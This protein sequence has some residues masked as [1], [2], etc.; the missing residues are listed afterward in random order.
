MP[1]EID[2]TKLGNLVITM[3]STFPGRIAIWNFENFKTADPPVSFI[4]N[5]SNDYITDAVSFTVISSNML[6]Y[7][8][9]NPNRLIICEFTLSNTDKTICTQTNDKPIFHTNGNHKSASSIVLDAT[10][11]IYHD[12]YVCWISNGLGNPFTIC[13][14][15]AASISSELTEDHSTNHAHDTL[16]HP[17]FDEYTFRIVNRMVY[18]FRMHLTGVSSISCSVNITS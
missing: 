1:I 5:A 4:S 18:G 10:G 3:S 8:K 14:F 12:V 15:G 2:R 6:A 9:T 17:N 16:L 11:T 7:T 13:H